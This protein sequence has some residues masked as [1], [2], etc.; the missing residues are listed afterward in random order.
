MSPYRRAATLFSHYEEGFEDPFFEAY[1][2]WLRLR[3]R[4]NT[5]FACLEFIRLW[6]TIE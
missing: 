1:D 6:A 3:G 4:R 2:F 5:L